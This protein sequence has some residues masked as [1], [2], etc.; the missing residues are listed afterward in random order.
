MAINTHRLKIRRGFLVIQEV[1]FYSKLPIEI[2]RA[3]NLTSS[4]MDQDKFVKGIDIVYFTFAS[5]H[6]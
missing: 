6:G 5:S 4:K 1:T 2:L 3:R